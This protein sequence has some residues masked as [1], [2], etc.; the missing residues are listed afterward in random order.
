MTSPSVIG[1]WFSSAGSTS[2]D[3]RGVVAGDGRIPGANAAQI[4]AI[5]AMFPD[6]PQSLAG[7]LE[8]KGMLPEDIQATLEYLNYQAKALQ[9]ATGMEKKQI[10]AQIADSKRGLDNQIKIAELNDRTSRYGID[11]RTKVELAQLEQ[12]DRQFW[13]NHG[14]EMQRFGLDT[15]KAFTEYGRTYDDIWALQDL[16]HAVGRVSNNQGPAPLASHGSPHAKTWEDFNVLRQYGGGDAQS[17]G[18]A[19]MGDGGGDPRVKAATGIMKALP[20]SESQGQDGQD[21]SELRAIE[22]LYL[23]AKPKQ[24]EM[25]GTE[26][27]KAA[28]AGL[29]RLGYNPALVEEERRRA[30]PGQGRANAA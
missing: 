14:L 26:R 24:V 11:E 12:N 19:G 20:P 8:R 28:Q 3:P 15:A 4:Q 27:R 1:P 13:A 16:K 7:L 21:W 22:S 10:E 5:S 2:T 29:G 6:L 17:G 25:L 9:A 18:G 30:L 23:S